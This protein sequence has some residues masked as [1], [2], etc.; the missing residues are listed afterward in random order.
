MKMTLIC[1]KMKL[2]AELSF[3]RLALKQRHKKTRLGP[4]TNSLTVRSSVKESVRE[5]VSEEGL[6]AGIEKV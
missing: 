4:I 3:A 6:E 1:M 5:S 2:Q